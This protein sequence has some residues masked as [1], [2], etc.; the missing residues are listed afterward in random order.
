MIDYD[1]TGCNRLSAFKRMC[2]I[3]SKIIYIF[4]LC[5]KQFQPSLLLSIQGLGKAF[6][7]TRKFL[8]CALLCACAL[9]VLAK[10]IFKRLSSLDRVGVYVRWLT[11]SVE[12]IFMPPSE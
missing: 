5:N 10:S 12:P 8:L 2:H 3:D 1:I 6:H 9:I 4:Q 7:W 11:P